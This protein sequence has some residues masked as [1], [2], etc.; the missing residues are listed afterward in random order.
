MNAQG[1]QI[2]VTQTVIQTG[3]PGNSTVGGNKDGGGTNVGAIV[4]GVVGGVC[5]LA[6]ILGIIFL[7]MRKR[8]RSYRD[9]FDDMMVSFFATHTEWL[10]VSALFL[11]F[12]SFRS[13]GR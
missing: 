2:I 13:C 7:I 8:K 3:S 6:L 12:A 4:G 5:G 11:C 9:D 1:S 10:A